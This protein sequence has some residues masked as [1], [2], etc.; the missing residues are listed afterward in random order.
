VGIIYIK[1]KSPNQ[2][3]ENKSAKQKNKKNEPGLLSILN[4]IQYPFRKYS[5]LKNPFCI[6]GITNSSN[7][8]DQ[9]AEIFNELLLDLHDFATDCV[10]INYWKFS[11][12]KDIPK[13]RSNLYK[14]RDRIEK[15]ITSLIPIEA[16]KVPAEQYIRACRYH[17]PILV[18]FVDMIKNKLKVI[19]KENDTTYRFKNNDYKREKA[20]EIFLDKE[21]IDYYKLFTEFNKK[22][23]IKPYIK[24]VNK[25]KQIKRKSIFKQTYSYTTISLYIVSYLSLCSYE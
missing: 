17:P 4:D 14:K 21:I 10:D 13:F 20:V 1:K 23:N 9:R 5:N 11:D 8:Y 12:K 22:V 16:R 15:Q 24:N 2:N 6:Y 25:L 3:K 7:G 18:N 19:R